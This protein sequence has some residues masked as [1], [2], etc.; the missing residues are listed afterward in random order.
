MFIGS[1]WLESDNRDL[2][3]NEIHRI[4]DK[5]LMGSGET[6]W[7]KISRSRIGF[8][9]DLIDWFIDKG[10]DLRF[11]CIGIDSTKINLVKYHENDQE[12]GF[13]KFYYQMLHHWILES[14]EYRIFCDS[15]PMS[16][17]SRLNTLQ[18][19]LINANKSSVIKCVQAVHSNESVLIQLTDVLLGIASAKFNESV[20][21]KSLKGQLITHLEEKMGRAIM[22]T[23]RCENKF[24]VFMIDLQGGW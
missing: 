10:D 11:R 5:H 12:L 9:Q 18:K 6:K 23:S 22:P 14:F 1:V 2:F 15:K 21:Q 4:R 3:K 24:N 16:T 19:C 7:N 8:Y 17:K 13:Y 20:S